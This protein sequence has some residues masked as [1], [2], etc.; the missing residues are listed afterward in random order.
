MV[1]KLCAGHRTERNTHLPVW[2]FLKFKRFKVVGPVWAGG[3]K[4]RGLRALPLLQWREE[5]AQIIDNLVGCSKEELVST[6]SKSGRFQN[7][8]VCFSAEAG[9][10]ETS[11]ESLIPAQNQRWRRA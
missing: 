5:F 7:S 11:N 10:A 3:R 9:E 4:F 8:Q 2:F 6:L 1:T